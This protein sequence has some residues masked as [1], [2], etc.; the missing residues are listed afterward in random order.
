MLV[1]QQKEFLLFVLHSFLCGV[2]LGAVYDC[3]RLSRILLGITVRRHARAE[4]L[5]KKSYPFIGEP[6]S[7]PAVSEGAA[8]VLIFISDV[9]FSLIA[10][11]SVLVV[12]FFRNDGRIRAECLLATAVGAAAYLISIGRLTMHLSPY[13]AFL[14]RLTLAYLRLAVMLPIRLVCRL[15]KNALMR[16]RAYAAVR[17]KAHVIT[18][19]SKKYTSYVRRLSENAFLD[20]QEGKTE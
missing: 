4:R 13:V 16:V 19:E 20:G 17:I 8:S 18:K 15:I 2:L 6:S 9:L 5:Y 3:F 7:R 14:L 10:I 12:A 11:V 1:Y